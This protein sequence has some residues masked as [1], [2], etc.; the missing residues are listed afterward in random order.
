MRGIFELISVCVATNSFFILIK[1]SSILNTG[2]AMNCLVKLPRSF[3]ELY[4][5][6][7]RIKGRDGRSDDVDDDGG[8]E[9]AIC[10]VTGA[11]MKSGSIKRMKSVS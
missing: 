7:N 10:L 8:C 6:V 5:I 11:V 2:E 1:F 9:T 4:G 3:V